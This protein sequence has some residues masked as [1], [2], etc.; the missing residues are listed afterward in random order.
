MSGN[1][2]PPDVNALNQK[3]TY[4]QMEAQFGSMNFLLPEPQTAPQP[5][6]GFQ[7]Q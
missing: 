5:D 1:S 2:Q 7:M 6:Q 4:Q 3:E